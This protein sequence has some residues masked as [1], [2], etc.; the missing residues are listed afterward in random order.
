[1]MR[2]FIIFFV[3][4]TLMTTTAHAACISPPGEAGDQI[5]NSTHNV[6]QYCNGTHWIAMGSGGADDLGDHT[7][8]ETLKME[9]FGITGL[10]APT[11]NDSAATKAYV[12]GLVSGAANPLAGLSCEEGDVLQWTSGA[13]ACGEGGGGGTTEPPATGGT[14]SSYTWSPKAVGYKSFVAVAASSDGSTIL[15]AE[16]STAK[17]L[18]SKDSGASW[19]QVAIAAAWKDVAVSADGTKMAAVATNKNLYNSTNGGTT[20]TERTS[21]GSR[22]YT[23][24]AMSSNGSIVVAI[25]S[26]WVGKS[27]DGGAT[28]AT[29]ISGLATTGGPTWTD[30]D[31]DD[32]GAKFALVGNSGGVFI[33]SGTTWT[34]TTS[35]GSLN[36]GAVGVSPDGTKIVAGEASAGSAWYSSNGG[37]SFSERTSSYPGTSRAFRSIDYAPGGAYVYAMTSSGLFLSTN[38]GSTWSYSS[39]ASTYG[40]AAVAAGT[41]FPVVAGGTIAKGTNA[42]GTAY[43]ALFT[44]KAG[45]PA[46]D[47]SSDGSKM[48]VA[49]KNNFIYRSTNGGTSFEALG[50][51]RPWN[52]VAISEDGTKIAAAETG[53]YIWTSSDSGVTWTSR[54]GAGSRVW[55]GLDYSA[56]GSTL[57]ASGNANQILTSTNN[58]ASWTSRNSS[59]TWMSIACGA[60]CDTIAAA[61]ANTFVA[62]SANAGVNWS[63]GSST[64]SWKSVDVSGDGSHI[65]GVHNQVVLSQN[66]GSS[67][68]GFANTQT[69]TGVTISDS[70][71][72]I[73]AGTTGGVVH[74]SSDTGTSWFSTG[75]TKNYQA[76]ANSNDGAKLYVTDDQ[77]I[78]NVGTCATP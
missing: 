25:A 9:G 47:V 39:G 22:V 59:A 20:W 24:I 36:W 32:T 19:T 45:V 50:T 4:A 57:V 12:D 60:S 70:G 26:N 51:A 11:G 78:V 29:F 28:F 75:T 41:G 30:I 48:V 42:N 67:W 68:S 46:I 52:A 15:A 21:S 49:V 1:M 74:V 23:D 6:M 38:G 17:L 54:T 55:T 71:N 64:Q 16:S 34:E 3:L 14:C 44:N 31:M 76:I 18:L 7:A 61:G 2:L 62:Y 65:V 63:N 43:T 69:F 8:T 53:G 56:D 66:A 10:A 77:G 33:S 73:A 40:T 58:G 5:Y 13:W 35:V 27:T 37:A 72:I